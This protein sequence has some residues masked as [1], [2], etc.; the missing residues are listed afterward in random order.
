MTL[1]ADIKP[2]VR[3]FILGGAKP[4]IIRNLITNKNF[5]ASNVPT[6]IRD[7][8]EKYNKKN[9]FYRKKLFGKK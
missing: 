3:S 7:E 5:Y 2:Y 6:I 9:G 8:V 1:F 4:T